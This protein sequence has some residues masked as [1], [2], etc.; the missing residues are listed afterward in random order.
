MIVIDTS[1]GSRSP[2][3][4]TF[5]DQVIDAA[6]QSALV[7]GEP[8]SAY[9]VA[10]GGQDT[11]IIT[12]DDISG[13]TPIGPTPQIRASRFGSSQRASLAQLVTKR[14]A[15]AY[16]AG[17]PRITSIGAMYQTASEH[18]ERV[19]DVILISD[20]VNDDTQVKLNQPLAS[21]QGAQL[22]KEIQV[23]SLR[24]AVVTMVGLAQVD[25]STPPPSPVWP[26]EIRSFNAALCRASQAA[27]CRLFEAASISETLGS[28]G[29]RT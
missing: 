12:T 9:G 3:L 28:S 19:G 24:G 27:R 21:G 26:T 1:S 7:C 18:V 10:G 5:A 20:G 17:Y 14:L 13:F 11:P 25:T 16:P 2:Q 22:A 23:A 8:F 4:S 15:A 6:A 29:A